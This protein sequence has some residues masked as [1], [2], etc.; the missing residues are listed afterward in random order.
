MP[1]QDVSET[2]SFS[3]LR[4]E[5]IEPRTLT[6]NPKPSPLSFSPT[7]PVASP[8]VAR[9]LALIPE[10][11]VPP[12]TSFSDVMGPGSHVRHTREFTPTP[13][14]EEES[15]RIEVDYDE[16][17]PEEEEFAL[18]PP[19]PPPPP[20]NHNLKPP[21]MAPAPS[22][23]KERETRESLGLI[24]DVND[25]DDDKGSE[26][27]SGGVVFDDDDLLLLPGQHD[28]N[29]T[30]DTHEA[31]RHVKE[32]EDGGSDFSLDISG[33]AEK[34]AFLL[35]SPAPSR[36]LPESLQVTRGPS[37]SPTKVS[38]G[39]KDDGAI[40]GSLDYLS[41]DQESVDD[42]EEAAAANERAEAALAKAAL[43]TAAI[44]RAQAKG[45]EDSDEEV[46]VFKPLPKSEAV[47]PT[48]AVIPRGR[49]H[50]TIVTGSKNGAGM[51]DD[52]HLTLKV[53]TLLSFNFEMTIWNIS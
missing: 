43:T 52:L 53:G 40:V 22:P 4:M 42:E 10:A 38:R 18:P 44:A 6:P 17:E 7:P 26:G 45:F 30:H 49:Y 24:E 39:G 32:E 13:L 11:L 41:S 34:L 1:E 36:T 33:E 16:E 19:P 3:S 27:F 51:S 50:L 37:G 5:P 14:C 21:S 29:D 31:S 48:P 12:P 46:E 15:E 47:A 9:E 35:S 8:L 2:S 20:A 28:P 23:L 25:A